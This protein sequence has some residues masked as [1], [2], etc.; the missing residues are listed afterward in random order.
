[1]DGMERGSEGATRE[2]RRHPHKRAAISAR[3][4]LLVFTTESYTLSLFLAIPK[5]RLPEAQ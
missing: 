3:W 2:G 5:Y 1:M 4:L